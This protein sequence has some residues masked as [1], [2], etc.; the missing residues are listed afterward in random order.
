MNGVLLVDKD[1]GL[2][3]HDVVAKARRLLGTKSIGHAGTLDPM[4]SGLLLLLVGEATKVSDYLLTGDK[5]YEVTVR[6]G[7]RTDSMDITGQVLE[8]TPLEKLLLEKSFSEE[9]IKSAALSASGTLEL[10]VPMHSAVK[11]NGKKLYESAHKGEVPPEIPV[12]A[13]SFYDLE[14]LGSARVPSEN[15]TD[16]DGRTVLL[17][18]GIE[19]TVRLRCSKGSFI[20]AW[21]NHVGQGL[22]VGGTLT[23]LRR[24]MSAPFEIAQAKRLA[25][26]ASLRPEGSGP[27]SPDQAGSAWVPLEASL[28]HFGRIEVA[29]HDARLLKNGQIS[30]SLQGELLRRVQLGE[31]LKPMRILHREEGGRLLALLVAQPGEFYKIRRVFA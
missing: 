13:M 5:G 17:N 25:D 29:G 19:F 31:P 12:R 18:E 6:L 21:G 14:W 16:V 10:K 23:K 22:G 11:V 8:Q 24:V 7:V 26:L 1:T 30:N 20:R 4:A 9:K 3:S 27:I 2:T 28:P 15:V